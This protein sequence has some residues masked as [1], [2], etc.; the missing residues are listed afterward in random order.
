MYA[1]TFNAMESNCVQHFRTDVTSHMF[2]CV[3]MKLILLETKI[4][5]YYLD[6]YSVYIKV[7]VFRL[8]FKSFIAFFGQL[9][10]PL[11]GTLERSVVPSQFII[12]HELEVSA[13]KTL[14][15]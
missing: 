4:R 12:A 8:F 3:S 7:Y 6:F 14:L 5:K 15:S 10:S 13:V 1:N 11:K 9:Y 2:F